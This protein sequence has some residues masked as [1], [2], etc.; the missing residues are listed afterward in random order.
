MTRGRTTVQ[1]V[2]T[3][4]EQTPAT[5]IA[6]A[7]P[8]PGTNQ[9]LSGTGKFAGRAGTVRLSG[10]VNMSRLVSHNEITFDCI[11]VIDLQ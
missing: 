11:F 8:L 5:H 2:T 7:I 1:P 4:A 3:E 9:V 6:G 10:A